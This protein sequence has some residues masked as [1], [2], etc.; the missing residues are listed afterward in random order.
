MPKG[1]STPLRRHAGFFFVEQFA[2]SCFRSLAVGAAV[3]LTGSWVSS[4]GAAQSHELH[5]TKVEVLGPSDAKVRP[6]PCS[7]RPSRARY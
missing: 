4:P 7:Q 6:L 5:V 2:D 1:A 3:R